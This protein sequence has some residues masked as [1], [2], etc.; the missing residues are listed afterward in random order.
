VAVGDL[1]R[2]QRPG[3]GRRSEASVFDLLE[4]LVAA[5]YR[6]GWLSGNEHGWEV[7]DWRERVK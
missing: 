1:P 5:R 3:L 2:N 7:M 4:A 6:I